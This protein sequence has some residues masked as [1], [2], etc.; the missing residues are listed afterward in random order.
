M[1]NVERFFPLDVGPILFHPAE[2][3]TW[4]GIF[5]DRFHPVPVIRPIT[6]PGALVAFRL[7]VQGTEDTH[8]DGVSQQFRAL[9]AKVRTFLHNRG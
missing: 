1:L 3:G 6:V 7:R 4:T 8:D 2:K 9:V 5:H